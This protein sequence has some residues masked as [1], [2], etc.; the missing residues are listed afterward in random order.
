MRLTPACGAVVSASAV[1]PLSPT[2]ADMPTPTMS[3]S[4]TRIRTPPHAPG[5][6]P[7]DWDQ[8]SQD[9]QQAWSALRG[10]DQWYLL[11]EG[12]AAGNGSGD[13]ISAQRAVQIAEA[14]RSP[15]T[16][17]HVHT[18]RF[19]DH[20]GFCRDCDAAYCCRHWHVSAIGYGHCPHG[21]D[22]SLDR[23]WSPD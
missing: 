12:A 6:R 4:P 3:N 13:S 19:Y 10:P 20:A 7:A 14:F 18:A 21:H 8:W 1:P 15:L 11:F 2:P 23:H 9:R 16:W 22:K 5:R 17:A